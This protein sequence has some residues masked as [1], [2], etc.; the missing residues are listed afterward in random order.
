MK[1]FKRLLYYLKD[2][3]IFY[4]LSLILSIISAATVIYS[5]M[6]GKQII[7]VISKNVATQQEI[8]LDFLIQKFGW[9]MLVTIISALTGYVS[10]LLFSIA[11]NRVGKNI[12]DAAHEK[13]Q[14]LPI[15]YFDDKPAGKISARIVNDTEVLRNSFYQNFSSQVLLN[16]L[17]VIGIYIALFLVSREVGLA[18]L[19]LLPFFIIW[20]M[21]YVRFS[22]PINKDWREIVSELNSL[23]AEIIQ[24]VSIVQLFHQ[25]DSM[26]EEFE[27]K[28]QAWLDN[29][30]RSIRLDGIFSW[31]FSTFIKNIVMFFLLLY[32]GTQFTS[33]LLGYSMGTIFILINYISSLFDP[34]LNLVRIM[35]TLQQALAS[36]ERVFELLDEPI[37]LDSDLPL[38]FS[39]GEVRFEHVTFGYDEK[40]PVL[41]DIHFNVKPGET[42]GLVGHTG[43]GKS[44]L[45]NLLFRFYDP[46]EGDIFIDEQRIK[47]CNRESVREEMGIVLQEPYLFSGTIGS[48]VS[49]QDEKI[50]EEMIIDALKKVGAQP[51]LDKLPKGIHE[52]VIE[53]GQSLSSGE[54]QLIA[55]ARTLAKNPKILILD[56]ATSHIDTETEAI[57]QNAMNVVKEGRTT[58]IIAHRL[59]TIQ[60]ADQILLLDQGVIQEHGSHSQL[61]ALN[62]Q[63]AEM[64]R[65]QAK[66]AQQDF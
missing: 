23:T 27:E 44:S 8:P 7:D 18:L 17:M 39:K 14:K 10:Q 1:T 2:E 42:I 20:Q 43:S 37:E 52:P 31:D 35:P 34:I 6:I 12:R 28:N 38:T 9:F 25:Q 50:T 33:G 4:S 55:F 54:R 65:L 13:M 11:S 48:N 57:I 63:Y 60:Q 61:I 5:P 32:L 62:G 58:F 3:P 46:Q 45:I 26:L 47:G 19:I 29:R 49:M 36:G 24:G 53:K 15:S 66:S 30:V 59:S 56:E 64:Y 41:K 16:L 40:T 22:T 21:Y 51:L